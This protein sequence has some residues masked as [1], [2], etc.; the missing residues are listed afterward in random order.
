MKKKFHLICALL[1]VAVTSM[2]QQ[3]FTVDNFVYTVT[4]DVSKTVSVKQVSSSTE[5]GEI[6]IP[7]S[8]E[9]EGTT[10]TVTSVASMGF[11]NNNS[12]TAVTLPS[13]MRTLGAESFEYCG[14]LSWIALNEGLETI[15]EWA[16]YVNSSASNNMDYITIPASVTSIGKGAFE[17][18]SNLTAVVFQGA[19][20]AAPL[21]LDNSRIIFE[22][23]GSAAGYFDVVLFRNIVGV[24]NS[25]FPLITTSLEVDECVSSFP[26]GL[27]KDCSNL[28]TIRGNLDNLETMGDHCFQGTAIGQPV[29]GGKMTE[30]P[31]YAFASC[32]NLTEATIPARITTLHAT[33]FW[34]SN[35]EASIA[36]RIE[37]SETPLTIYDSGSSGSDDMPFYNVASIWDAYIGRDIIRTAREGNTSFLTASMFNKKVQ[38]LTFGPYVTTIGEGE[39]ENSTNLVSVSFAEPSRLMSIGAKAFSGCSSLASSIEL[40]SGVTSLGDEAFRN[41]AITSVSLNEGL[42]TIGKSAFENCDNLGGVTIP[43]SVQSIGHYAFTNINSDL[44]SLRIEDA[45]TPITFVCDNSWPQFCDMNNVEVYQGRNITMG[46]TQNLSTP[47][48]NNVTRI[49]FG[50]KVTAIPDVSNLSGLTFV[51]THQVTPIAIADNAFNSS[52]YAN[53]E[54]SIPG[55]S[56]ADYQEATGWRNFSNVTTWSYVVSYTVNGQGSMDVNGETAGAGETKKVLIPLGGDFTASVAAEEGYELTSLLWAIEDEEPIEMVGPEF[57][58]PFTAGG[59]YNLN[60]IATFIP[61]SYAITYNLAGGTA[62]A[63][64][65]ETYNIESVAITLNNPTRTG[66]DFAGWTESGLSEATANVTI[67]AGSIGER[68]YTA[69]WTPIN[70][71][72]TYD[73]AGGTVATANPET[74]TIESAAITLNNPTRTGY[75]FAGWTGTGLSETTANVTIPAGSMGER[76]YTATW[77][78][79]VYSISYE[80]AG[81]SLAEGLTNPETY[82]IESEAFTLNNPTRTGYTF[83]GWTG[84]DLP[85]A[86]T[87]VTVSTGSTGN[88]TYTATW[89]I[90]QYTFTF[91]S[92]GGTDVAPITLDYQAAVTAPE[93]PTRTG[94][95]F[96]G[97]DKEI[98]AVMPNEDI[99][100]T[101]QWTPTVYT[102]TYNLDGGSLTT[103]NPTTYT[104]ESSDIALNNPTKE[105]YVFAGWTGTGLPA[106][107]DAVVI[108]TGS[109]GNRTYTATW[110]KE[111]YTVSITGGGVTADNYNPQ[112]GDNVVLTITDDPDAVLSSLVVDGIDVTASVAGGSY[113]IVNVS[114]NVNVVATFTST[115]EFITLAN[116][117]ATF[118]CDQD[119]DFTGS[120][121]RAY[122]AAGFNKSTNVVLLL[123]V[124]DVP[125]GTG[126]LLKGTPGDTYKIPYA[127]SSSYYVNMLKANLT[128]GPLPKTEGD[129]SNF[130]LAKEGDDFMFKVLSEGSTLA[131]KRAY[132]QVPTDMLSFGARQ[133]GIAFADDPTTNINEYEIFTNVKDSGLIYNLQGQRVSQ[134]SRGIVIKNGKKVL[135]TK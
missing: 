18:R 47:F 55:G 84:A 98:P 79:I 122:I 134:P 116:E 62:T 112:Y 35:T 103:D 89:Q 129:M 100:F 70:Y 27:F 105:H 126:L 69:T 115:K 72:I 77:T 42:I 5:Y 95:D 7:E 96:A 107:S 56:T 102:I 39:Y 123:R 26:E 52:A 21:T 65:P 37:D 81:G 124:Y 68:T 44:F 106:A 91:D 127:S 71:A 125:A 133:L 22:G 11:Q 4:D 61:I 92:N 53:A 87:E 45:E 119:L 54:L 94:Y 49:E 73:L 59:Y 78:P 32:K 24:T 113:T 12:L 121:V 34:Y 86:A 19:E 104:I 50:P 23:C 88:R 36:V 82:T 76:T 97:W 83:M 58:N 64:N 17:Y 85:A 9:W 2:A 117:Q 46:G 80:L 48:Y 25:P 33:A 29:I 57:V 60:Y 109:T 128:A 67:P 132:L 135:I 31:E 74:Y 99:T 51:K 40:P 101:A 20:D 110:E 8:V 108:A 114:G 28:S 13:T 6:V 66:Y 38:Y 75:D 16:F 10:Y 3:T 30:I 14:N 90:N 15:E 118:S 131:A 1:F 93:A 41:S 43:A 130:V 63:A 111:T 120:E